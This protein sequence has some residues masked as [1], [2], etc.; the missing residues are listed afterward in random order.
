MHIILVYPHSPVIFVVKKNHFT[1]SLCHWDSL[2]G[3]IKLQLFGHLP[4]ILQTIKVR[5]TKHVSF[6]WRNDDK[7][8]SDVLESNC[9]QEHS[10]VG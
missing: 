5:R 1:L 6:F 10:S 4:P 8:I 7:Q 9:A 3:H 2:L